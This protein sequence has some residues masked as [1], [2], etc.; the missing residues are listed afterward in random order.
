MTYPPPPSQPDATQP[1]T[2]PPAKPRISRAA[3][4][5]IVIGGLI[6]L[7]CVGGVIGAIAGDEGEPGAQ[8]DPTAAASATVAPSTPAAAASTVAEPSPSPTATEVA[9]PDLTGENAQ[10]AYETLTELGFTKV[11]FG[12]QDADDQI[13]LYPPNWTVTKQSA[14]AGTKLRTDRTIVL[15]CTKEG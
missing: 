13:V 2:P 7:C 11:T 12:S 1:L 8:A 15:T 3:I 4:V 10:I 6:V 5:G 9:V 14:E